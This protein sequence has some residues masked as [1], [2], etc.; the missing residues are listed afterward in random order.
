MG[1]VCPKGERKYMKLI[2]CNTEI[3]R[4]EAWFLKDIENFTARRLFFANCP[5]CGQPVITLYE[6]RIADNK[7]FIDANI[8]GLNAV[9]T[10]YREK[11][12]IVT[13]ICNLDKNNLYGWIY[14][15]NVE[16]RNKKKEVTQIR[17]YSSDFHG[18]KTLSKKI[19]AQSLSS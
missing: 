12:R 6:K 3:D 4:I 11:S 16:I 15:K 19:F 8:R 18:N 5:I 7:V 2:C 10:L 13:K 9:K 1:I 17:Q 14:G